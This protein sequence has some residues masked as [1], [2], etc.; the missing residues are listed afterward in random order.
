MFDFDIASQHRT[1]T[2]PKISTLKYTVE[3]PS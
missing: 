1:I 2:N 3:T